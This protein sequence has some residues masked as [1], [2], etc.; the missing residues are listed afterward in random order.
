M[1]RRSF[2]TAIAAIAAA[3]FVPSAPPTPMTAVYTAAGARLNALPFRST[4]FIRQFHPLEISR[5][6]I[7]GFADQTPA[8]ACRVAE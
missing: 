1:T 2:L 4:C 3:P 8:L 6:D 7:Y 5:L